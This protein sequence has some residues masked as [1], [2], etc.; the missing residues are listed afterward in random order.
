MVTFG[1]P[2]PMYTFNS[3]YRP[4]NGNPAT[5]KAYWGPSSQRRRGRENREGANAKGTQGRLNEGRETLLS[6]SFLVSLFLLV[7][8][9]CCSV[10]SLPFSLETFA[11]KV[12]I[13]LIR[14][15]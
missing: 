10:P 8:V 14:C 3:E 1:I 13:T 11:T 5:R 2:H 15:T 7:L 9:R 6:S 12:K 4:S